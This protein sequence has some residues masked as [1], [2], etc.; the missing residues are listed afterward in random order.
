MEKGP[1]WGSQ[2]GKVAKDLR[3]ERADDLRGEGLRGERGERISAG[4]GVGKDL[5]EEGQKIWRQ[6]P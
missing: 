1:Q 4:K 3:E 6:R 5:R 2:Q